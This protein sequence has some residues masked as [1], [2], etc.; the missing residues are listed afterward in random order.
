[1][2]AD[3]PEPFNIGKPAD[4]FRQLAFTIAVNA[5]IGQVLGNDQDLF[6][7]PCHQI[8]GFIEEAFHTTGLVITGKLGDRA[9]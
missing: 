1:M 5:V 8:S 6:H 3:P 2:K 7:S 4:Q 9:K